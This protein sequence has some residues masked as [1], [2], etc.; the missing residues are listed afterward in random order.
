MRWK[1][2]TDPDIV[3]LWPLLRYVWMGGCPEHERWHNLILPWDHP[4]WKTHYCPNGI[5]C[6]CGV[7]S[8]DLDEVEELTEKFKGTRHE[9]KLVAPVEEYYEWRDPKTGDV[10][11]IPVG[12]EPGFDFNP[13]TDL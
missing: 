2:M 7:E 10:R 13:G 9:V 8:S 3:M 4:F 12:I 5:D 1:Q 11:Q 6:G